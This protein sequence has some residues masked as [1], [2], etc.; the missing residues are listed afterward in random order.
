MRRQLTAPP[1]ACRCCWFLLGVIGMAWADVRW[2]ARWGG[3]DGFAKLLVIPLLMAQFR[4]SR[5][6]RIG[7]SSAF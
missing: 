3:L 2:H 7:S 6:R 4:R 5:I 1:A